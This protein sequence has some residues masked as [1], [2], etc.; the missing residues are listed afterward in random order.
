[1]TYDKI[2]V[3]FNQWLNLYNYVTLHTCQVLLGGLTLKP[4]ENL[5]HDIVETPNF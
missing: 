3:S 2:D 5:L 4:F 1:M